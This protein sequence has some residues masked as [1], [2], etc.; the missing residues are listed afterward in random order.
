M[1]AAPVATA[2]GVFGVIFGAAGSAELGVELTVAM[3]LLV[4]SGTVQFAV[5]G[6]IV[7]G[8]GTAAILLTVLALNARNL[9]LGATLRPRLDG[10]AWR[11]AVLS[12]FLID[13]SF[14]LSLAAG[15]RAGTVL[16]IAGAACYMAWQAGTLLGVAGAR[17]VVLEGIA[18]A[19]FPVLFIGLAALTAGGRPGALRAASAAL[20]VVGLTL[21]VPAAHAVLPI[22]TALAV[23]LP[24]RR[25]E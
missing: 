16:L 13:E 19:I 21:L 18:E 11:R 14:G 2:I 7:L 22:L 17:V 15:R 10:P 9:V 25:T 12:W 20:L 3:S 6:L 23:A 5:L 24:G 8:A 1:S 4:F